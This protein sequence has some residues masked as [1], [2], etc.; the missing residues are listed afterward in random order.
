MNSN[1]INRATLVRLNH[2]VNEINAVDVRK[3]DNQVFNYVVIDHNPQPEP[4][5]IIDPIDPG[6][7]RPPHFIDRTLFVTNIGQ[8]NTS[9]KIE[10]FTEREEDGYTT[11]YLT[12]LTNFTSTDL[13]FIQLTQNTE[14][15]H[16]TDYLTGLTSFTS[17]NLAFLKFST[18]NENI[19][20]KRYSANGGYLS[21]L[22]NMATEN[23]TI[24][25][26]QPKQ[27]VKIPSGSP[28]LQIKS[29]GGTVATVTNVT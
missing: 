8:S 16:N 20:D 9:A 2:L 23:I 5:I 10:S 4:T 18:N 22:T 21:G 17:T 15:A 7:V 14:D 3:H 25:P 24:T 13:T 28:S 11:D 26:Y 27:S 19:K 12:G 1:E 29:F 6:V